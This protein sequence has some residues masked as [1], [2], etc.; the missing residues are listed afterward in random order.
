MQKIVELIFISFVL[1]ACAEQ[2]KNN[3]AESLNEDIMKLHDEAMSKSAYV[4]KLKSKV[5]VLI[6]SNQ[7]TYN[8]DT[9]QLL[10]SQLFKADRLMLDWMHQYSEP[11]MKSDTAEKYLQSQL[12]MI[13]VVHELTFNSIKATERILDEK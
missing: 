7:T 3:K 6:D 11:D 9:L 13:K 2:K 4:L 1:L 10:S 8:K 5:N 12:D